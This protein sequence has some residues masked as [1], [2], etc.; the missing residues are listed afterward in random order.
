MTMD[1][2][3]YHHGTPQDAKLTMIA[4][5]IGVR[6]CEMT[7]LTQTADCNKLV[8]APRKLGVVTQKHLSSTGGQPPCKARGG[9]LLSE[10]SPMA[11]VVWLCNS[12]KV[13]A[14]RHLPVLMFFERPLP[15]ELKNSL[16]AFCLTQVQEAAMSKIKT[17]PQNR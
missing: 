2:F 3:R 5:K 16:V 15:I 6:R 8:S 11:G 1:W 17:I 12:R 13:K 4:K 10:I 7:A 9:F 14:S